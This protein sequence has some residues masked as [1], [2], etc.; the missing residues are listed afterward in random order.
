MIIDIPQNAGIKQLN[1]GNL[2]G[3][4][5]ETFNVDLSVKQGYFCLPNRTIKA[6]SNTDVTEMGI[7][8]DIIY[9]DD[10]YFG[11][12]V[13]QDGGTYVNDAYLLK[14][15]DDV[16]A[17]WTGPSYTGLTE[18][19]EAGIAIYGGDLLYLAD[20]I[21][22]ISSDTDTTFTTE[23][24]ANSVGGLNTIYKGRL[25][26]LA[27]NRIESLI[28]PTTPATSGSY[29][30]LISAN[31][32]Y[33]TTNIQS[34]NNGIWISTNNN[35]GGNAVVY[36][37]DGLTED[38][39]DATYKIPDSSVM[40]MYIKDG[41]PHI[42][43]GR[44]LLMAFNGAYFE[45][46]ARFPFFNIPLYGRD[47]DAVDLYDSVGGRW[48]HQNGVANIDN[49]LH[50]LV[51]PNSESV[52]GDE[53]FGDY[54]KLAGVW[55][56]DPEIGLYHRFALSS[57]TGDN[58][59]GLQGQIKQVGALTE[60]ASN[61]TLSDNEYGKFICSASYFTTSSND[62]EEYAIFGLL[63]EPNTDRLNI[64][65]FT[66]TRI[67]A[68]QVTENWKHAL[69]G[70]ENLDSSDEIIVK[71]RNVEYDAIDTDITWV[72]TT[73]F[74]STDT[75]WATIKTNFDA[76]TKYETRILYGNGAGVLSDITDISEAGGTYTVTVDETHTGVSV[77]DTARVRV[78]NWIKAES[79]TSSDN[80]SKSLKSIPISSSAQW[81][82]YK[83][84]MKG[85]A[86]GT[87]TF[88]NPVINR[89]ISVSE[90]DQTF[91]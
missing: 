54:K 72:D 8:S 78:E 31:T 3:S 39:P 66:T 23:S 43:T 89:F 75:D 28:D 90:P 65:Y 86:N 14:G 10:R 34:N 48:I 13:G 88:N 87:Q 15:G 58:E 73:S 46:V 61:T 69:L 85:V 38:I 6:S 47:R 63:D 24:T 42:V 7:L 20:D 59:V 29:T 36:L 1:K 33:Q 51:A 84:I 32:P 71:Y 21:F 4:L 74:T 53:I 77:S 16:G 25:Y 40:A 44:G 5:D 52:N 17:S 79:V 30:F 91:L 76:G 27:G 55:C 26:Y 56:Y 68:E 2:R 50:F 57:S 70:F 41:T 22:S 11:T 80:D 62:S 81:I 18:N 37:W 45:E 12:S 64:G 67:Y 19:T 82:Q 35:E 83:V 60:S 9:Y 49:K